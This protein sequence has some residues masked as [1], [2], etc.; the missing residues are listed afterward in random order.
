MEGGDISIYCI[1]GNSGSQT[2]VGPT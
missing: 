1:A 2:F